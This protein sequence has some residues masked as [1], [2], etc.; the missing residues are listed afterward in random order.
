M[1]LVTD[2]NTKARAAALEAFPV[3]TAV[4]SRHGGIPGAVIGCSSTGTLAVEARGAIIHLKAAD[5]E[6]VR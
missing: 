5:A 6:R 4:R 2:I 1:S 3:G